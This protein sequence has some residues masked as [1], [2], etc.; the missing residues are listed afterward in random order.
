MKCFLFFRTGVVKDG[1]GY[2]ESPEGTFAW[3][4]VANRLAGEKV[5]KYCGFRPRLESVPA[6]QTSLE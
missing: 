5:M 1:S 4:W 3:G 6:I 2:D